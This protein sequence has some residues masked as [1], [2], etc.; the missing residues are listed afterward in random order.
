[1]NPSLAPITELCEALSRPQDAFSVVQVTGTNG[2]TSTARMVAGLLRSHGLSVGLYTSPELERYPERIEV[3]HNAASDGEFAQA[4]G[5]AIDTATALWGECEPGVPAGVTEFELLTAAALWRFREAGVDAAVLEVGMGGRWDATS[6]VGP[7]VA[8]ITGVGLDHTHILGDTREAIAAEKAAIIKPGSVP[9]LGPGTAGVEEV[10]L[11]RVSG[12]SAHPRAVRESEQ[13]SPVGEELTV[14]FKV[15]QHPETPY[16]GTRLDVDGTYREYRDLALAAPAYQAGNV[17][18][19]IAAVEAFLGC[20]LDQDRVQAALDELSLPG[21]FEPVRRAPAI[22]VD[23][24]HNPQAAAVLAEAIADAWPGPRPRPLIL[25]GVLA[26]KDAAGIVAALAP[27]AGAFAVATPD[28]VRA[29][30]ATRLG[31]VVYELTGQRPLVCGSVAQAAVEL[32]SAPVASAGLVI[33]G[34]LSTAG[35]ARA[36]LRDA[37]VTA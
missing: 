31:E 27:V 28:S 7:A 14:R 16:G 11:A 17:A 24:S 13:P 36:A 12:L 6:V 37:S 22:V 1:M 9:V 26:D 2:K 35:Q 3:N 30:Q 10:F 5:V 15:L 33:T 19:A 20:A 34:S 29:L 18:T 32:A 8:V 23:G 4:V 21:R 25:L